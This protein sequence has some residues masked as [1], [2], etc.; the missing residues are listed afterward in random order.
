MCFAREAAARPAHELDLV[1]C[2]VSS[3]LVDANDR[4]VDHLNRR[5]M[6]GGERIYDLVPDPSLPPANKTIVASR[7]WSVVFR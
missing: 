7:A 5:I 4:C 1:S 2:N 3:M 6:R